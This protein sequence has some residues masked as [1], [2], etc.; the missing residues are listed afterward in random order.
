[1]G[2]VYQQWSGDAQRHLRRAAGILNVSTHLFAWYRN[3]THVIQ[4]TVGL[5]LEPISTTVH[6]IGCI[7]L[8]LEPRHQ[9]ERFVR[10][11]RSGRARHK[12]SPVVS[13]GPC[14]KSISKRN[15]PE[16]LHGT[17][18]RA[19]ASGIKTLSLNTNSSIA[20]PIWRNSPA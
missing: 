16:R 10:K 12:V 20:E 13:S 8:V 11:L 7:A 6:Q 15:W 18:P 3:R 4:R 1:M 9:L 5:L 14:T 17:E 19:V 2:T